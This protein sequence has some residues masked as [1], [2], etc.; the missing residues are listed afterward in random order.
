M[1]DRP[2][3]ET[4]GPFPVSEPA[5][6]ADFRAKVQACRDAASVQE[7]IDGRQYLFSHG[8]APALSVDDRQFAATRK[9]DLM[10][11]GRV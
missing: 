3:Q 8:I 6:S 9:L 2:S 4:S 10:K 1:N 5:A 11:R 7:L